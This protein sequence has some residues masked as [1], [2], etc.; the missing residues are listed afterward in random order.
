MSLP[1]SRSVKEEDL[2]GGR[3]RQGEKKQR[4]GWKENL[5][6]YG[7]EKRRDARERLKDYRIRPFRV[8]LC[9]K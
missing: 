3:V 5:E 9:L 1:P 6:K 2:G 8:R 7:E 4:C